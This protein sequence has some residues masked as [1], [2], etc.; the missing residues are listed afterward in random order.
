M[1]ART[2]VV[3]DTQMAFD[4]PGWGRRNNHEAEAR[5]ASLLD[6][7]RRQGAP[8]VHVRHR[9]RSPE[10]LFRGPGTE[11]KPEARPLPGEPVI[12]K[13][14]NSA[15]IGTDLEQRLR[16]T[17]ADTIV[18][19]GMTTDH[20]CSTTAR[21]GGNLGFSVWFVSDATATFER[22]ALDG[23]TI[24]PE[25]MHRIEL[26]SLSGEFAEIVDTKEAIRRLEG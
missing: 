9:S 2:L 6:A 12:E 21:M 15:F 10:G 18:I 5:I 20:C 19:A 3:I 8:L 24:D 1:P 22:R 25:T 14:V 13:S 4:N 7:W 11:F 16:A 17:G 23:A 26:A